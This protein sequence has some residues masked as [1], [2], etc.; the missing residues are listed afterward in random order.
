MDMSFGSSSSFFWSGMQKKCLKEQQPFC[1]Y[2]DE[3]HS[4]RKAERVGGVWIPE[5]DIEQLSLF[6]NSFLWTPSCKRK[7]HSI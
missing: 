1:K 4:L 7:I 2:E 5:D 6:W 3:S